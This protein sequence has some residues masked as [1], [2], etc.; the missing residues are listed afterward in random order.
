[1][2]P[3]RVHDHKIELEPGSQPTVQTQWRLTQ[4]ELDELRRQ[5]DYLLAKGFVRP[6]TSPFAAHTEEGWRSAHVYRLPHLELGYHQVS[7]PH[8]TCRQPHRP[9]SRDQQ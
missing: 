6:S 7:L 5:L 8:S 4:L 3:Q 1:L 9:I 2:P